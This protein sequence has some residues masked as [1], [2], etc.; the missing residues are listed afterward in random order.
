MKTTFYAMVCMLYALTLSAQ[1]RIGVMFYNLYRFPENPPSKR[2]YILK[3]IL[4]ESPPDLLMVCELT[5][6]YG[7]DRILDHSLAPLGASYKRAQFIPTRTDVSDPLQ[8]M[9]FYNAQKLSLIQQRAYP[10][11]VRDINHYTFVLHADYTKSDTVFIDVFIAHFK[12]SEGLANQ[13]LRSDMADTFL[14]V[15]NKLPRHH[16]VLFGGDFN[17]YSDAEPAYRKITDTNNIN[18]MADPIQQPGFWHDNDLFRSIHTQATRSSTKGFG[19]GGA[20]GGLD[21]RFDFIFMSDNFF[22]ED[23]LR[24]VPGSYKAV[25]NNGNC[26]NQR[27]DAYECEGEYSLEM[28]QLLHRMSD[29]TPLILELE[30]AL[31][32]SLPVNRNRSSRWSIVGGN[33]VA[34]YI[35]VRVSL[36]AAEAN[37]AA[38][39][40]C[41]AVGQRIK[42]QLIGEQDAFLSLYTGDLKPGLYFLIL[43]CPGTEQEV[44]KFVRR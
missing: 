39:T 35:N 21:D 29:H 1:G 24:Y 8:Q 4:G 11:A 7:A 12:S 34:E 40:I 41:N 33:Y 31:S 15:V 27:I 32:L 9:V 28:R 5:S 30:T 23:N 38:I 19:I 26:L 18:V 10:T 2:E 13:K 36:S 37:K 3:D 14:R 6:E 16:F 44:L 42:S 20:S 25:G 43:N 22:K 17:F